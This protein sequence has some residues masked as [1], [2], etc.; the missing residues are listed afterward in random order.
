MGY[1]DLYAPCPCGSGEK[2][3]F[4]CL[5]RDREQSQAEK[6]GVPPPS[7]TDSLENPADTRFSKIPGIL[8][9][10]DKAIQLNR[11]GLE[12]MVVNKLGKA[13][14]KFSKAMVAAPAYH[15]AAN[16]LAIC[17]FMQ[18]KLDEA[19][20]V[21]R[22][23]IDANV[24]PNPFGTA[25]LA[26]LL[27]VQGDEEGY[28]RHLAQA[29][30]MEMP[31]PDPCTMVCECLA[32]TRRHQEILD[33]VDRSCFGED[34]TVA[35]MAGIAAANLGK[36]D[37][38]ISFL[39]KASTSHPKSEVV[40]DY[41]G[42]L[43]QG[44]KPDTVR[45]DWPY[46]DPEEVCPVNLIKVFASQPDDLLSQRRIIVDFIEAT[47]NLDT[48]LSALLSLLGHTTHPT[49]AE[50]LWTLA[51]GTFGPDSL[52]IRAAEILHEKGLLTDDQKLE[53]RFQGQDHTVSLMRASLN[54]GFRFSEPLP[55]PLESLY[56][57]ALREG[58]RSK[59]RW[60][61]VETKCRKVLA[62]AP[63]FYPALY[64]VAVSLLHRRRHADAESLLREIVAQHPDY[65]FAQA[66]LLQL[67]DIQGHTEEA[68]EFLK[69]VV[70]PKETHPDAMVAW[71]IA[72]A[73][74]Y[75]RDGHLKEALTQARMA[76]EINPD[77]A[78]A[79]D[80][81]EELDEQLEAQD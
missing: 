25:H 48:T 4:C 59:P 53:L 76:S 45:G 28:E 56:I 50:L 65:L 23:A 55:P 14:E 49:A 9:D 62:K 36:T 26:K 80:L 3:K 5:R 52:R 22:G 11:K 60:D 35:L 24:L 75:K 81:V 47:L 7:P 38:A 20:Q 19:I 72:Q 68:K 6:A 46:F 78:F 70:I 37:V 73:L 44:S 39:K 27:Y 51:R 74:H 66:S 30:A 15:T 69:G 41:I 10:L 54:P 58:Q 21:Q 34:S 12:L 33:V 17:L 57:E 40:S 71:L 13:M 64:N 32:R 77:H 79:A 42:L 43:R 61:V 18:G 8:G 31:G 67:L 29:Q 63:F 1:T 16:N 2:Y